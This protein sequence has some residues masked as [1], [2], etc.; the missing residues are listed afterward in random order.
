MAGA[1]CRRLWCVCVVR[2]KLKDVEMVIKKVLWCRSYLAFW[3]SY[4][5]IIFL[6][7]FCDLILLFFPCIKVLQKLRALL[8]DNL[9]A[10]GPWECSKVIAKLMVETESR[11]CILLWLCEVVVTSG[12]TSMCR[13]K[14]TINY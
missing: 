8:P 5:F 7:V 9:Q 1:A 3:G 10:R 11:E 4:M 13:P 2:K 12:L 6:N 14:G